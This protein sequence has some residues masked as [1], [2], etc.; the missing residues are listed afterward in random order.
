MSPNEV[1]GIIA[2]GIATKPNELYGVNTDAIETALNV[3]YA[4]H[5]SIEGTETT[6][7]VAYE[8]IPK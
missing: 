4:V 6:P 2:D 5:T 1:Y 7:N 8:V 3:V